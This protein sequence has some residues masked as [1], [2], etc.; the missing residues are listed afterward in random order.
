MAS[1]ARSLAPDKPG[2]AAPV[3]IPC[4]LQGDPWGYLPFGVKARSTFSGFEP[5]FDE[6]P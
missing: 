4:I 5:V 1:G 6:P 2:C 3:T